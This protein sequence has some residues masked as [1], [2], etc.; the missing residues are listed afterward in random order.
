MECG[1]SRENVVLQFV[2]FIGETNFLIVYFSFFFCC[3]KIHSL[4]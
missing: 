2:V 1:E 4:M 3:P